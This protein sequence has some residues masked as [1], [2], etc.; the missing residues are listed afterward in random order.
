MPLQGIK[1]PAPGI[2]RTVLLE[3]YLFYQKAVCVKHQLFQFCFRAV[4]D[5]TKGMGEV[6]TEELHKALAVDLVVLVPDGDQKG[7]GSGESDKVL[8]V[9]YAAQTNLKFSHKSAPLNLYKNLLFVYNGEQR[10]YG[11][12]QLI[13]KKQL[14]IIIPVFCKKATVALDD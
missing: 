9:F 6:Q 12:T 4:S 11:S 10:S 5:D 3:P 2:P 7:A 13:T 1:K 8:H 14:L